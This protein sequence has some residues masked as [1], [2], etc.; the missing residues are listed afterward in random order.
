VSVTVGADGATIAS[1][2][3]ALTVALPAGALPEGTALT[4]QAI[5]STAPGAVGN[6]WRLEPAG[7]LAVPATPTFH[8]D[9]AAAGVALQALTVAT[10]N[11][12]AFWVRYRDVARDATAGTLVLTVS[13]FSDW[14][15]V[16]SNTASDLRGRFTLTS[17][18]DGASFTAVGDA[19]LNYGGDDAQGA[20]YLQWGTFA[21]QAPVALG[22]L[23]CDVPPPWELFTNVADLS[24][25]AATF[26]WGVSAYW[27]LTCRDASG[28]GASTA[29]TT[30]FDTFGINEI[31]CARGWVTSPVVSLT[32]VQGTYL[33]DC[34]VR[35][36]MTTD[37]DFRNCSPGAAC[38]GSTCHVGAIS[39][40]GAYATCVDSGNAANGTACPGGVCG[41]GACNP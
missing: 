26:D 10:Q 41:E 36:R 40:A 25:P 28:N 18:L 9:L 13:H 19:T 4:L 37:L 17:N 31:G 29:I 32:Q 8:P 38:T 16:T 30:A 22:A 15:V 2:D 3:G 27:S 14:A 35:G 21:L 12:A 20:H 23:T 6:A 7:A 5:T 11:G 1:G 33:I 39:C 34:G 24:V